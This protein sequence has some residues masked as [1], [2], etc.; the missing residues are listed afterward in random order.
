MHFFLIPGG[1][2]VAGH[3]LAV[4]DIC[5]MLFIC[6]LAVFCILPQGHHRLSDIVECLV[7]FCFGLGP[8][9]NDDCGTC[10]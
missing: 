4:R 7:Y 2:C 5:V 6:L 10:L 1:C 9:I 8:A 3:I